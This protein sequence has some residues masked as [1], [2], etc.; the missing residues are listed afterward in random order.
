MKKWTLP[1]EIW[2]NFVAMHAIILAFPKVEF[3]CW[4]RF[5]SSRSSPSGVHVNFLN[6]WLWRLFVSR[7]IAEHVVKHVVKVSRNFARTLVKE[8]AKTTV[9]WPRAVTAMAERVANLLV[10]RT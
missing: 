6:F 2:F 8:S 10:V 3:V 7:V 1:Q 9:P 5:K 4:G